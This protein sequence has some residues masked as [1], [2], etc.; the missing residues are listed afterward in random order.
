LA[1]LLAGGHLLIEDVPGVGKTTLAKSLADSLSCGFT[2]IQFTPDTLP[3]D[4]VG[5]TIYNMSTGKFDTIQGA[6]MNNIIMADEINR[7]SPKT[8]ASLLEAMEEGQVT[9]DGKSYDLPELFM[10]IATENCVESSGTYILPEAQLDRFMIRISLGYPDRETELKMIGIQLDNNYEVNIMPVASE[11]DIIEMRYAVQR[12]RV[13][14][15]IRGYVTDIIRKTRDKEEIVLGA[16]PRAALNL[17]KMAQAY[18]YM[19]D[20]E[21]VI[22]DDVKYIAPDV[23]THR[24]I[25]KGV[26]K[27]KSISEYDFVKEL[28]GSV[29][30]PD[31][32][33]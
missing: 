20:R 27:S 18:A 25:F 29:P 6:I 33:K 2:R 30:V 13:S 17:I 32:V 5:M 12:V 28:V 8:Q 21:F 26:N 15:A 16:S 9:I 10:V 11:Q 31:G 1:V 23:L 4:V 3:S 7:T 24:M 22:P 14:D 19:D